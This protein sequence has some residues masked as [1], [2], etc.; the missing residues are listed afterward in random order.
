MAIK[1]AFF[2]FD[3]VLR[4]WD[5]EAN[6]LE[7]AHGIPRGAMWEIVFA[8]ENVVPAV[9]GE[10]TD[11]AWRSNVCRIL[12]EKFPEN[13]AQGAWDAWSSSSG[14]LFPDVLS[15]IQECK[16]KI[17]VGL[18]TNA[19][20]RLNRDLETL[21]ISDLFN[22]VINASEIGSIKPEPGIFMHAV[23]MA[24]IVVAIFLQ[25]RELGL[26]RQELMYTRQAVTRGV[27]A[28]EASSAALTKQFEMLQ[29]TAKINAYSFQIGYLRQRL[30]E[31]IV[32]G[33]AQAAREDIVD[34]SGR[35]DNI[36]AEIENMG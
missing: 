12:I 19:T 17:P 6:S 20:S 22:Y 3:G 27:E 36:M 25:R 30:N 23:A 32:G 11:E 26:Q 35:L 34:L 18:M 31:G 16:S 29:S 13:D 14:E 10:I 28:Q 1:C 15:I 9:R 24:G 2:D 33:A 8:P 5:Y 21:G 4:S 7:E